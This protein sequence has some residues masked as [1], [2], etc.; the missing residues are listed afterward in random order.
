M[1]M[2]QKMPMKLANNTWYCMGMNQMF[3][4]V[5]MGQSFQFAIIVVS[6]FCFSCTTPL[7]KEPMLLST[8]I[9]LTGKNKLVISGANSSCSKHIDPMTLVA[10]LAVGKMTLC[11]L[12][13]NLQYHT[14]NEGVI[15][16]KPM[17]KK[18]KL[19]FQLNYPCS[20][21]TSPRKYRAERGHRQ[22]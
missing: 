2:F 21:T 22:G 18:S 11:I 19:R 17:M 14:C 12:G 20:I 13:S 15:Y 8:S 1:N 7:P 6:I 16:A 9:W 4:V 3:I 5:A 10:L